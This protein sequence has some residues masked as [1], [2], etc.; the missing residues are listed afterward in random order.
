MAAHFT[1]LCGTNHVRYGTDSVRICLRTG[2]NSF[3]PY[4]ERGSLYCYGSKAGKRNIEMKVKLI[5]AD[6]QVARHTAAESVPRCVQGESYR[7]CITEHRD[8]SSFFLYRQHV[9]HRH[10]LVCHVLHVFHVFMSFV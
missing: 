8:A 1:D 4:S 3:W 2:W 5:S 7:E 10:G 6:L 9:Y